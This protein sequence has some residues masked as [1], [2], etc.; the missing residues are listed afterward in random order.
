MGLNYEVRSAFIASFENR[1]FSLVVAAYQQSISEKSV[2]YDWEEN[3]ITAQLHEYIEDNSFRLRWSITSNVEHHILKTTEKKVKGFSAKSPRIDLRF[4]TIRSKQ[5]YIYFFESKNL[6]ES[7]SSLKRRY[8]TT[9]ID[10]YISGK[11]RNGCLIGYLLAG[12]LD[13]TIAG[14]NSML[15]KDNRSSEFL[16]K[17]TFRLHDQYYESNHTALGILKHLIFDFTS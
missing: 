11:Y 2:S 10:N 6:K 17:Q 8:I 3:D 9:G 4:A 7:D 12:N 5:E 14:I 16:L 1:C 15:K 13:N